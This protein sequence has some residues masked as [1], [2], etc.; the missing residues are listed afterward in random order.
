MNA[1]RELEYLV[2]APFIKTNLPDFSAGDTVKLF[3][4]IKEGDKERIQVFE[5][6]V[7]QRRGSGVSEMVTVRKIS[8]GVG[9][10][11][12]VPLHGPVLEKIEVLRRG[13]VRRARIFYLRQRMGKA[14][15][16]RRAQNT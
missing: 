16:I 2:N 10:E 1:L 8:N 3:L 11:R 13:R 14:A 5:G 7:I 15:K 9:V 12:I 4:R 6:T